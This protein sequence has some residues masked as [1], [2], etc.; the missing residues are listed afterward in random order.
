MMSLRPGDGVLSLRPQ[1]ALEYREVRHERMSCRKSLQ[2]H[3]ANITRPIPAQIHSQPSRHPTA[4]LS[5][6]RNR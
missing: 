3:L 5:K 4:R 2:N 1:L 6:Y